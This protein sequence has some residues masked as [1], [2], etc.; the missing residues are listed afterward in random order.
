MKFVWAVAGLP[1]GG[2]GPYSAGLHAWDQGIGGLIEMADFVVFNEHHGRGQGVEQHIEPV[3]G[4]NQVGAEVFDFAA[5]GRILQLQRLG[6]FNK[7]LKRPG[8]FA[9][10]GGGRCFCGF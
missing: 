5:Q 3:V 8:Q 9:G 4:L 2:G 7:E 6:G 10:L 1:V